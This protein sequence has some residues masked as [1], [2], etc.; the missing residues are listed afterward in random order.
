M[1]EVSQIPRKQDRNRE[2]R[3]CGENTADS[4][5]LPTRGCSAGA[6]AVEHHESQHHDHEECGPPQYR[7]KL[8][9]SRLKADPGECKREYNNRAQCEDNKD[10]P[11]E[12]ESQG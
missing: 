4:K 3:E 8:C 9:G 12:R 11:T 5:P 2:P 10:K 6:V 7:N 1:A